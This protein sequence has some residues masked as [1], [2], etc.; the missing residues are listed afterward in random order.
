MNVEYN[1]WDIIIK[2]LDES[3][4]LLINGIPGNV[5]FEVSQKIEL[6]AKLIKGLKEDNE[7]FLNEQI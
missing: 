3:R 7:A 1:I 2:E 5:N 6:A 4:Q